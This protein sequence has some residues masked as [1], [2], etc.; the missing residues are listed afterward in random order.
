MQGDDPGWVTIGAPLIFG[1]LGRDAALGLSGLT[2]PGVP[3]RLMDGA[4]PEPDTDGAAPVV[5]EPAGGGIV[6]GAGTMPG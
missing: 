5:P 3:G 4:V 6:P 1:T 2:A